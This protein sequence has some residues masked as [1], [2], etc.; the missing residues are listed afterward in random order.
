MG[1]AKSSEWV[2]VE[3]GEDLTA[4][5]PWPCAGP[6]KM[7]E[8]G[9][10]LSA[11]GEYGTA[12]HEKGP[13]VKVEGDF[14]LRVRMRVSPSSG[15]AFVVACGEVPE[16]RGLAGAKRIEY[17]LSPGGVSVRFYDGK[18]RKP[19]LDQS[20][21]VPELSGEAELELRRVGDELVF[22]A[23]GNEVARMPDPGA[24]SWNHFYL[25]ADV[26]P[27][28]LLTV[29]GA[30]ILAPLGRERAV[31]VVDTAQSEAPASQR[32]PLRELA[33]ARG[34]QIGT[35][36]EPNQILYERAYAEV[37]NR[38]FGMLTT[39]NALKFGPVHPAP[40]RYDWRGADTIV[41]FAEAND[42]L[43]R[44]HT[45]VWH[46]QLPA[47]VE[48]GDW[49]R[50]ELME[51]LREHITTVV[52]RYKGRI[53]AWDVV[54]EAVEKNGKL[55]DTV[56]LRVIGPEYIEL[57][58]RWA[59]EADPKALLF[60][61]DYSAETM[62]RKSDAVYVLVQDLLAKG[63]P[64]HGVGFQMHVELGK[65]PSLA[66]VRNNVERLGA[67]GL[68]VQITEMDVRLR[69][70]RAATLRRQAEIYAD[71]L[72]VCLDEPS[73]TAFVMWG[74]A[75]CHSW[76][77]SSFSGWGDALVFDDDYAPKPAYGALCDILAD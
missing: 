50:E 19:V 26:P 4:Y 33:A 35:A 3:G 61:N 20:H 65:A 11:D 17:G 31:R 57:A 29:A 10:V 25:G 46:R 8:D 23:D 45:L 37:L 40:N 44:G 64:I 36:V 59:H 28:N 62:N 55:R 5:E 67:L 51:V 58:F 42:M 72:Q 43:V 68:E 76:I 73:C 21:P 52:G 32:Q 66:A 16:G 49:T 38:E 14:G 27:G 60:Y 39:E 74:F 63:V 34:L 15:Q 75:D 77:P 70:T 30:S 18:E 54:N 22:L 53:A 48:K 9:L 47:W 69:D 6:V 41:E 7:R 12:P 71:T 2:V 56:W 24:F 13:L 1:P